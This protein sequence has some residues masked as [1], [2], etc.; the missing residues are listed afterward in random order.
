MGDALKEE[1]LEVVQVM[2]LTF[3]IKVQLIFAVG[4]RSGRQAGQFS[5]KAVLLR[6]HRVVMWF[7]IVLLKYAKPFLQ[8]ISSG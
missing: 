3:H 7:I 4:E 6:S 5:T 2:L 8:K 1:N